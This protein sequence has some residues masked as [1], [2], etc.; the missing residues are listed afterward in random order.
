M[1]EPKQ[2]WPVDGHTK[3]IQQAV[4]S[5]YRGGIFHIPKDALEV[6]PLPPKEGFAVVAILDDSGKAIDSEYIEDH[7]GTTI[8][9][10]SDCTK[11]EVVSELGPIKGGFTPDKPLTIFDERIDDKWVT[12][13]SNKYIAEYDVVDSKRRA[14]YT[15]ISDPLYFEAYR[16]KDDGDIA[17]YEDFK[18]Q[19]DAAV[20]KIKTENPWP[21]NPETL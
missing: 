10:E 11:S 2:Y 9:D 18:A 20:D 6:Q 5:E 4:L 16:A 12:N 3:E 14:L 8:Y 15:Q 17:K 1:I 13:E 7:R 19:A 21:I